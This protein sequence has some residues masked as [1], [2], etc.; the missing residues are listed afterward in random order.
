MVGASSPDRWRHNLWRSPVVSDAAV[1]AL[2]ERCRLGLAPAL[3]RDSPFNVRGPSHRRSAHLCFGDGNSAS[4]LLGLGGC[5]CVRWSGRPG[6]AAAAD[7]RFAGGL[8]NSRY[9][10]L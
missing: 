9:D 10:S 5:Y 7:R 2:R 6:S 8:E 1:D 4:R 3:R